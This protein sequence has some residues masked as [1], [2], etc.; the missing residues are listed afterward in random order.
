MGCKGMVKD[1]KEGHL[2]GVGGL[3][4]RQEKWPEKVPADSAGLQNFFWPL[5]LPTPKALQNNVQADHEGH[6]KQKKA[7][8]SATL[9]SL[10]FF[11]NFNSLFWGEIWIFS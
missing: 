5:F 7:I 2:G 1:C 11:H 8:G 9:H 6:F 4:S 3:W 10:N